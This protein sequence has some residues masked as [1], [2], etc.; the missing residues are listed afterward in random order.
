VQ[1]RLRMFDNRVLR[2]ILAPRRDE[3]TGERRR[4]H[5]DDIVCNTQHVL[6]DN[7]IKMNEREGHAARVGDGRGT[8]TV[9]V[10]KP[11]RKRLRR[12]RRR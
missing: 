12:H 10:E 1:H 9:L 4:L 8:R 3:V 7:Q 5:N 2:K 11:N 6:F